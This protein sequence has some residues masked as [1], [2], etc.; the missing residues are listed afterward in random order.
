MKAINN[1][2]TEKFKLGRDTNVFMR[3]VKNKEELN[4]IIKERLSNIITGENSDVD[5][6]DLD[7]SHVTSLAGCFSNYMR[8]TS[9]DISTWNFS[10]INDVDSMFYGCSELRTIKFPDY[11]DLRKCDSLFAMFYGCRKLENIM[12]EH[13]NAVNAHDVSLLFGHCKE[14]KN[15]DL[16]TIKLDYAKIEYFDEMFAKCEKLQKIDGIE[17]IGKYIT[18]KSNIDDMFEKCNAKIIPDWYKK[19]VQ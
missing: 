3:K 5:F 19:I 13:I 6:T 15:V 12:Y 1:Y 9:I 18:E 10:N 17:E 11:V 16:T 7:I 4:D 2:I 8:V 14:L